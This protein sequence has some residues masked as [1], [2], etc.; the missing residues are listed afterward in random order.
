MLLIGPELRSPHVRF[1]YGPPT[2]PWSCRDRRK[3]LGKTSGCEPR[4][5]Y[6]YVY[7]YVFVFVSMCVR[8]YVYVH[9]FVFVFT[10]AR[11]YVYVY[12]FVFARVRVYVCVC[13]CVYVR[14]HVC[15]CWGEGVKGWRKL[16]GKTSDCEPRSAYYE[17]MCV[18]VYVYVYVYVWT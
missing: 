6:V 11:M 16:L 18:R 4:S 9:V 5:A 14:V 1:N 8:V 12:V 3:R 10:C 7:V 17:R 2:R 15:A 13:V